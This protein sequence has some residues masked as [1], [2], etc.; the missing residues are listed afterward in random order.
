MSEELVGVIVGGAIGI[1][2][3]VLASAA[4]FWFAR[5]DDRRKANVAK[6][7]ALTS[8]RYEAATIAST[9][10]TVGVT[11][12]PELV[13]I[14][15]AINGG[16]LIEISQNAAR[17]LLL[18]RTL[19]H[20]LNETMARVENLSFASISAGQGAVRNDAVVAG[21]ERAK[22]LSQT[23]ADRANILAQVLSAEMGESSPAVG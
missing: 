11:T 21:Y 4:T 8:C 16:Y 7:S 2:A 18:F 22:K 1:V 3:A 14:E 9:L 6:T 13:A 20:D 19:V 12:I 15:R 17:E 23:I 10:L 5:I